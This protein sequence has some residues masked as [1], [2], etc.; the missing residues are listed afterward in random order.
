MT[1]SHLPDFTWLRFLMGVLFFIS[2]ENGSAQKYDWDT[3]FVS[4]GHRYKFEV[5]EI[6]AESLVLKIRRDGLLKTADTLSSGGLMDMPFVDINSDG[7]P[8]LLVIHGGN[9]FQYELY[10]L[11]KATLA[12]QYIDDFDLFPE[13]VEIKTDP[14]YYYSYHRAGCADMVWVSDLFTIKNSKAILLGRIQG[15]CCGADDLLNSEIKIS[16]HAAEDTSLVKVFDCSVIDDYADYKWGFIKWYWTSNS[17]NFHTSSKEKTK[18]E[19]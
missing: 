9:N 12:Y 5:K 1:F 13:A 16:N 2:V 11:N 3:S 19:K 7:V 15:D 18:T 10:M 6:S 4:V 8:D 14:G 17:L